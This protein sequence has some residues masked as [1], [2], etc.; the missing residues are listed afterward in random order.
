MPPLHQEVHF[1]AEICRHLGAHG[2]L[3][4]EGAATGFDTASG[5]FEGELLE[6]ETLMQPTAS[7]CKEQFANSPKLNKA[8]GSAR[9]QA[10][11]EDILQGPAQLD[12]ALRA[13]PAGGKPP[14]AP[15]R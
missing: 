4:E 5:L 14:P 1:E 7:T 11:L 12:E 13:K 2:W 9:V 10:G 8:L 15:Q 6:N 3:Y